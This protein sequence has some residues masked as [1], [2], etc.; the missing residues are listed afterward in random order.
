MVVVDQEALRRLPGAIALYRAARPEC[1][2]MCRP[3][4]H[5]R[6]RA[7]ELAA[8]DDHVTRGGAA[9]LL[10]LA[11]WTAG[12]LDAGCRLYAEALDEPGTVRARLGHPRVCVALADIRITQGRLHDAMSTYQH[13]LRRASAHGPVVSRGTA[14]MHVGMSELFLERGDLDNA[15]EQ[16]LIARELGDHAGLPQNPYRWRVAMARLRADRRRPRRCSGTDRRGRAGLHQRLLT[17]GPASPGGA[18]TGVGR[19]R[20]AEGRSA[21]GRGQGLSVDD[22]L[23]YLREYEHI[24]LARALLASRRQNPSEHGLGEVIGFL[25]RLLQAAQQGGR[26][27]TV[28]EVLVVLALAR[29][30][31]GDSDGALDALADALTPAEPEEY[32]RVFL[33]E[34][35]PMLALLEAAVRRGIVPDYATRLL[36]AA[37]E[38]TPA[39][40]N[41]SGLV[42]PLSDRERDVLRLLATD[43][44]GPQI[45]GALVVSLNT[46]RTH[47][48]RIYAKLGVTNRRLAVRRAAELGLL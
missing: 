22:V 17:R 38:R 8:A 27:G 33:D 32:V 9:A 36:D 23:D 47:T 15:R 13:G 28:I 2:V 35:R 12:D 46:V 48:Q 24:T 6:G 45:A 44:S 42:E 1:S 5:M 14:D 20:T 31:R 30:Y 43:L 18:C 40:P 21:L 11:F 7:L 3:P 37:G 10:G 39:A 16:L 41:T 25:E 4:W 26:T 34:G 29:Q 19:A